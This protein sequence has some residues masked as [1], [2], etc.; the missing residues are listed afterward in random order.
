MRLLRFSKAFTLIEILVVI[1]IVGILAGAAMP[2]LRGRIEDSKWAEAKR[3]AGLIRSAVRVKFLETAT[4]SDLVGS[5]GN[6]ALSSRLGFQPND[7]LGTYFVPSDY[8]IVSVNSMGIAT[9]R[10]TGSQPNAPAGVMILDENGNWFSE[11]AAGSASSGGGGG[12]GG[13]IAGGSA[14]GS[15]AGSGSNNSSAGGKKAT[16]KGKAIGFDK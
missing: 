13:E 14:G 1:L 8:T 2:L 10:I 16:P 15:N 12:N 6:A 5:L 4:S 9:I 3:A 11:Q 7:L